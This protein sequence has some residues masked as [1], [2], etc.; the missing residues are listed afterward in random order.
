L[1]GLTSLFLFVADTRTNTIARTVG[2]FD[3]VIRPFTV[4]GSNTLVFVNIN[5]L[6]GL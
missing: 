4:N 6:L 5:G 1:A 3:N 2:P